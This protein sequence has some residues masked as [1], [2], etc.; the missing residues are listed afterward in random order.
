MLKIEYGKPIVYKFSDTMG[1]LIMKEISKEIAKD[2]CIKF[3]YAH[4][5]NEN[6]GVV[7]VGIFRESEPEKCLGVASFGNLMNPKSYVQ[8]SD[9]IKQDE[10]LELN[11]LWIDD[12]LGKN[13]ETML[14]SA[15][16]T[17]LRYYKK[18]KIVQ[19][20][21]DGR[22]GCGTIYKASNFKYF[23]YEESYFFENTETKEIYFQTILTNTSRPYGLVK[24]N[25]DLCQGHLRVFLTRSYRYIYI[26]DKK[27]KLKFNE[28]PYPEYN[29]GVNYIDIEQ[30][31][32]DGSYKNSI[33]RAWLMSKYV[34]EIGNSTYYIAQYI[35]NKYDENDIVNSLLEQLENKTLKEI[36]GQSMW[37]LNIS[38]KKNFIEMLK[39]DTQNK[40]AETKE[41]DLW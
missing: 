37:Y 34:N 14:L 8:F 3:H 11:R 19:S 40:K 5:W 36:Y 35:L 23:G 1:T 39:M 15:S 9:N 28:L 17:I 41:E 38:K 13:A 10:I 32:S 22:L 29:K 20:F 18:V 12:C 2:I 30:V 16:W 25:S 24:S 26:L 33:F 4:K 31:I 21:A 27:V 7:N 6:F